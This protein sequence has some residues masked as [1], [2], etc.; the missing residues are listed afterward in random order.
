MNFS[1]VNVEVDVVS[2][3]WLELEVASAGCGE[4]E[5]TLMVG[6]SVNNVFE[7]FYDFYSEVKCLVRKCSIY[8]FISKQ[9]KKGCDSLGCI[10]F[11]IISILCT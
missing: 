11:L 5:V 3:G 1:E 7:N 6:R 4:L 2:T 8:F 9:M 10:Y